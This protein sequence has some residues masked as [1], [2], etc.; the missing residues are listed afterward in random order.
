MTTYFL[1][2]CRNQGSAALDATYFTLVLANKQK[3][4]IDEQALIIEAFND[5]N[6]LT[7]VWFEFVSSLD[8]IKRLAQ[9]ADFCAS[10]L[11]WL[12]ASKLESFLGNFESAMRCALAAGN[13]FDW[14]AVVPETAENDLDLQRQQLVYI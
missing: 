11:A 9:N 1:Q 10:K 14:D 5:W 13:A 2:Q 12:L 7:P 6:L 3:Q 4:K 8:H